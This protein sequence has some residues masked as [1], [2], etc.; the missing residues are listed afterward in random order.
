MVL[1]LRSR[2][3]LTKVLKDNVP[4]GDG[5][6]E[7]YDPQAKSQIIAEGFDNLKDNFAKRSDKTRKINK[8][9]YLNNPLRLL[10]LM[11]LNSNPDSELSTQSD[12]LLMDLIRLRLVYQTIIQMTRDYRGC[13]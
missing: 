12:K 10:L 11:Y 8:I 9:S 3:L 7:N 5:L 2:S 13:Y 1:V 6:L 4:I